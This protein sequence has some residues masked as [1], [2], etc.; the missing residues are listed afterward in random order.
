MRGEDNRNEY[1]ALIV[2]RSNPNLE[3]ILAIFDQE[4]TMFNE[5][6]P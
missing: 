2:Q 5:L 6:K 4:T 3:E 1:V